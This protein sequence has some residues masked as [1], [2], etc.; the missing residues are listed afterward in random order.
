MSSQ[1]VSIVPTG[2][3]TDQVF[4]FNQEQFLQIRKY[5]EKLVSCFPDGNWGTHRSS[6]DLGFLSSPVKNTQ[7]SYTLLDTDVHLLQPVRALVDVGDVAGGTVPHRHFAQRILD[8]TH[9]VYRLQ[10]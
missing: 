5:Q 2:P 8:F 4:P 10:G 6:S 1:L 3:L 9:S 7:D